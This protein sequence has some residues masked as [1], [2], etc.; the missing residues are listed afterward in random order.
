MTSSLYVIR[1]LLLLVFASVRSST[2]IHAPPGG[3]STLSLGHEDESSQVRGIRALALIAE[4][5]RSQGR[6]GSPLLVQPQEK[7]SRSRETRAPRHTDAGDLRAPT[8]VPGLE[9][10]YSEAQRRILAQNKY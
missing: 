4:S 2:R 6:R 7:D 8:T 9:K 10:H 3:A 1:G 5:N